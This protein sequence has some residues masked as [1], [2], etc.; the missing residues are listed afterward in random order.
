MTKVLRSSVNKYRS[1]QL[2]GVVRQSIVYFITKSLLYQSSSTLVHLPK[3]ASKGSQVQRSISIFSASNKRPAET[4]LD[5]RTMRRKTEEQKQDESTIT[6]E[7]NIEISTKPV[8]K[9]HNVPLFKALRKLRNKLETVT[10]HHHL[11]SQMQ[12]KHQA[13]K[14]LRAKITP[15]VNDLPI[16]LYTLWER[17]HAKFALELTDILVQH[18]QRKKEQIELQIDEYH[19]ELTTNTDEEELT[20]I[21][22]LIEKCRIEK[23]ED[24]QQRRMKKVKKP[25]VEDSKQKDPPQEGMPSTS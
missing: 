11:L 16:D 24:L 22:H 1:K 19:K 21:T 23:K 5:G 9:S 3:M 13:P 10:H 20:Y 2:G 18:W 12:I 6:E 17:S 7:D 8:I 14:G 15:S 25:E 4:D